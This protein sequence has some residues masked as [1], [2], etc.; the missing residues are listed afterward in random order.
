MKSNRRDVLRILGAAPAAAVAQTAKPAAPAQAPAAKPAPPVFKPKVFTAHEFRTVKV[1]ANLVIPADERSG[2]AA[3]AGVPEYIDEVLDD[4]KG[5]AESQIRGGLAWLDHEA[6]QRFQHDFADCAAEQ[7]KE[8]LNLIA[9]PRTAAPEYSQ[10]VAFFN[11]FRNMTASGFYTS[12]IGIADL[13][14]MGNRAV[15][16]WDGCP[17]EVLKKLGL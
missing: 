12:K 16:H 15:D 10:A 4:V 1:L 7:Q 14:F 9:Y 2:N 8:I 5:R 3:Q 6:N 17:P 11:R 13:Q